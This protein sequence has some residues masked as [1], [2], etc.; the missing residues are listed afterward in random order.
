MPSPPDRSGPDGPDGRVPTYIDGLDLVLGGG[1]PPGRSTLVAGGPGA[2][3]TVM[4]MEFVA[5]GATRGEP[6]VFLSF[7]HLRETESLRGEVRRLFDWLH[8]RGV[9]AVITAEPM[10]EAASAGAT[11]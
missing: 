5:R 8:E 1:L 6:G 11:T 3:K 2:G 4:A 7:A 9:T 10:D